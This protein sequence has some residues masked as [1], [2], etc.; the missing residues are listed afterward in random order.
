[1]RKIAGKFLMLALPLTL[2][3]ATAH[4]DLIPAGYISYDVSTPRQLGR[5]RHLQRDG[6][7]FLGSEA[8]TIRST[9]GTPQALAA[10][11]TRAPRRFW[12]RRPLLRPLRHTRLWLSRRS[13]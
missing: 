7:E 12:R 10:A 4:A 11:T 13:C 8:L 1:V 2:I 9:A 5:V 6:R 3:Q